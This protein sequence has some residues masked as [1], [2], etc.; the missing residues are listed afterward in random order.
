LWRRVHVSPTPSRNYLYEV[1]W[2]EAVVIPLGIQQCLR[3][4]RNLVYTGIPRGIN[5]V[6]L[7]GQRKAMAM[8]NRAE[9][10]FSGLSSRMTG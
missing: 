8:S 1:G 4:Q 3:F 2:G 9:Q 7:I 10:P 5:L 6:V